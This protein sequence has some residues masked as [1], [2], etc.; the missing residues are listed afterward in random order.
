[1]VL[2]KTRRAP[3]GV[4]VCYQ[5]KGDSVDSPDPRILKVH[6]P[7]YKKVVVEASDEIRYYA[8]LSSFDSV[9]CFPKSKS[10][11]DRV[12]PDEDGWALIW[13]SRFEVHV[14]QV[15]DHAYKKEKTTQPA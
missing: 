5:R 8:D 7:E 12:G 15:I 1:M 10:D 2:G 6:T 3:R 13:A 4:A 14:D 11:W 9:H